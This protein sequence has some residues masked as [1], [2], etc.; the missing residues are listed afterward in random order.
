MEGGVRLE[1]RDFTQSLVLNSGTC[2]VELDTHHQIL[3]L[4]QFKILE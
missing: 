3:L 1:P 2:Q 4:K